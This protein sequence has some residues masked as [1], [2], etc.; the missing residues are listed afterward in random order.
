MA[1][2]EEAQSVSIPQQRMRYELDARPLIA[3]LDSIDDATKSDQ[4]LDAAAAAVAAAVPASPEGNIS[5][6]AST[7]TVTASDSKADISGSTDPQDAT[8]SNSSVHADEM[9]M[10]PA[11]AVSRSVQTKRP[12]EESWLNKPLLQELASMP[13]PNKKIDTPPELDRKFNQVFAAVAKVRPFY[14]VYQVRKTKK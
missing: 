9:Y 1:T 10:P 4:P 12:E 2:E 13:K 8:A 11:L 5:T 7:A 14:N 6:V 3:S